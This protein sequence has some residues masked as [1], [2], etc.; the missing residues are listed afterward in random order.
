MR[1]LYSISDVE[2]QTGIGRD[3]L[4]VWERRYG[5]PTPQRNQRGEREYS[6]EQLERLCLIKQLLDNGQRP[7]KLLLLNLPHLQQL[8]QQSKP[9]QSL[10]ADVEQMLNL[11]ATTDSSIVRERLKQLLHQHGLR[12]FLTE[13]VAPLNQAVGEA[14]FHG[15]LGVLE[16]HRYVEELRSLLAVTTQSLA[17]PRTGLRALL[18]TLPGEQ[19]GVGLLMAACI[20]ELEGVEVLQLGVQTPLEEIR[21]GAVENHCR[22]VGIS[23]S[24]YLQRRA[25]ASQLVRLRGMLPKE[26]ALWAGGS[27]A[28]GVTALPDSI[29]LF[30]DLQQIPAA[31]TKLSTHVTPAAASPD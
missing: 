4:R 27:G 24:S 10:S 20:L 14:W 30:H 2:Q 1:H 26:I 6:R 17:V 8:A 19:H 21:R 25:T 13:L 28:Q 7:G 29:Q 9:K 5:F 3:T 11:L 12:H 15:R 23:C 22:L 18:T 16:E 31:V